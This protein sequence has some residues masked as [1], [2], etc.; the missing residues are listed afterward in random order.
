MADTARPDGFEEV[1]HRGLITVAIMLAMVMQVL[2]MTIANI[3][4]PSMQ[5]SLG[6]AQDT[7]TWVLTSYIVASAIATPLT[8]WVAER[9]GRKRLFLICVA[10]FVVSS[11][12]CGSATN[13][14]QIVLYRILQG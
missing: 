2:D 5:A 10:G 4:L 3:A 6:A 11:A 13:L 8:G 12:L 7:I 1:P 9:I 14:T